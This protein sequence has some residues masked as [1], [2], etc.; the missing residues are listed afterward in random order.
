MNLVFDIETDGLDASVIWCI[1]AKD[2]DTNQVHSFC[3]KRIE[4][5]LEL[6]EKSKLLIGHNIVGFD[7]PVLK[8]LTGMSFKDKKV[9]DTLVLSRLANPERDG[10]GLKPW[11]FRLDYHKGSMEEEDFNEYTPEMLEYCINDV[12]LNTLVFQELLKEL[13][14]FGEECVKIEHEVADIL[15]QQENHGFYLDVVKAE[16]LLALFREENAKIVEEVHKVFTPR[17]VKVKSVVPK[18]KKDGT[19]SKQGLTE[20]EYERLSALPK[21]Q[22]LAFD[23]FK[24]EDFNLN[25]RQQIGMYLQDFGWKPKKFTPTGQPVV[26]EGTL[27]TIKDIPEA[28]LI[29]RF[30]LLNKRIGL[31]ESWFKFLKNDRVHG[32]TVHNGAVTGRMTHFKPNMAQIPAVYSPYGKECRECWTVPTG[33]KLVGIDASGLE[34]RMLAHYMN[35]KGYTYEILNGD[36]HTANQELAGLESR[37]QAKTFIYAF[38][39]GAGDEKL[40]SVVQGN[41]RDG[42]R[43]RGSFLNNLPSL[44]NLKDRVERASQRGYLKGLDDRKVTIRSPHSALNTLLQSAGAIIMKKA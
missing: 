17:K 41:R 43:L 24:I 4:E 8:K 13:K 36:I 34:L 19:L 39:Y 9:I 14:G 12:E 33:Y 11:G 3:P 23:R 7:I 44:A 18:F 38:L 5:G 25:S 15:K 27:K 26:D 29:N 32:Y 10:H 1:V 37:D 2:I 22:V 6:L 28:A 35:D 42:K 20:E 16:R 31:V 40:G 30:L 21:N